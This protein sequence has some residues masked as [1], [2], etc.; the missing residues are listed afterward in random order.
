ME[1]VTATSAPLGDRLALGGF[2]RQDDVRL[3]VGALL[4]PAIL[5]T[6]PTSAAAA[7]ASVI[8]MSTNLGITTG[9]P[10]G[11]SLGWRTAPRRHRP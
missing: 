11:D 4:G 5:R 1:T 6:R 8:V 3:D 7:W 2:L 9:A 10:D